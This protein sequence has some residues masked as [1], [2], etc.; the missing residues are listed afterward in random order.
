MANSTFS[1]PVRSQN[2]F[3][4]LVDGV[5]T[6][7]GGGGSGAGLVLV[8]RPTAPPPNPSDVLYQFIP[9][10][11][12]PVIGQQWVVVLEPTYGK[13]EGG[14][15]R[16]GFNTT[17]GPNY[18]FFGNM[19]TV[20]NTDQSLHNEFLYPSSGGALHLVFDNRSSPDRAVAAQLSL[21]YMGDTLGIPFISVSGF[22][23]I[24][25]YGP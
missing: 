25:G 10:P 18:T 7:V 16:L 22:R 1:G 14:I 19:T 11:T 8:T 13:A 5:W 23:N 20:W 24:E 3:Q 2:G 9:T 6:P 17:W 15:I 4:E 21:V 12:T